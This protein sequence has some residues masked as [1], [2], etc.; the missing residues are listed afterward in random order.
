[1]PSLNFTWTPPNDIEGEPDQVR[2][3]ALQQLASFAVE[4]VSPLVAQTF[5]QLRAAGV[6]NQSLEEWLSTDEAVAAEDLV[7]AAKA[8][9][10]ATERLA[11]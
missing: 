6:T 2:E 9:V 1:M 5:T 7:W 3:L 10:E 4:V 8:L 11:P